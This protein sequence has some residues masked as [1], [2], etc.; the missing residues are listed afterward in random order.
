VDSVARPSLTSLQPAKHQLSARIH[1]NCKQRRRLRAEEKIR[2]GTVFNVR[3]QTLWTL[4][5]KTNFFQRIQG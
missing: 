3:Q 2:M 5:Q 1:P 4:F